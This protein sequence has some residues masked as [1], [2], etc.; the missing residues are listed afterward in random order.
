MNLVIFGSKKRFV[1]AMLRYWDIAFLPEG[2][3]REFGKSK[4]ISKQHQRHQTKERSC[5]TTP[6][7]QLT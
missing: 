5:W 1:M 3:S 6:L 4:F 7:K 2:L